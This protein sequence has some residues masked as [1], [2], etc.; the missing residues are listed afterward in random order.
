MAV[1]FQI[2]SSSWFKI[3]IFLCLYTCIKSEHYLNKFAVHIEGG[4]RVARDVAQLHGFRHL[5]QIGTLE[6]HYLFEHEHV[7]RRSAERSEEHHQKLSSHPQVNWFE[8]QTLLT[9]KKRDFLPIK[10]DTSEL[11]KSNHVHRN[12]REVNRQ[13]VTFNDE[14]YSKMWYFNGGGLNHTD[15]N[16]KGAWAK[17]VT[18]KDVVITILDD[19]LERTHDDLKDNY[20]PYASY[21]VNG[22][23]PDP[24]PR[25]DYTNENRHGTRCAGEVSAKANNTKCVVGVAYNSKIG[26]VRMLDGD[27]YDAVEATSLSHNR[28]H[29]DIYSASWGPDDDG[30]VVDGPGQLAKKAFMDGVRLG[31]NG[32]GAIFVWASGNGGRQHDS[33]SC[34]G[35]TNSIYTLSISG[36]S[37]RI[38]KPFYLEECAST[39]ATTFSS[40]GGAEKKIVTVDLHNKCT[41]T[42]TGTSASAP[43]AAGIIALILEVNP[44]L[45]WRD[46]QYITL[47]TARPLPDGQ[48]V[49]N[50][51]GRQVS[52]RY[53]YGLM[54]ATAMVELAEKWTVVPTQHICEV[55]SGRV[56]VEKNKITI[57]DSGYEEML[58]TD[59][60]AGNTN[61]INFLEHVQAK[62][63]LKS[64]RRGDIVIHLTSPSGTRST[65]LPQRPNDG[66][67]VKGFNN[68]QF[69]SVHFWGE[70]PVGRWKLEIEVQKNS[71]GYIGGSS[72]SGLQSTNDLIDWNLSL[73]GT[74]ENPVNL[75]NPTP[76]TGPTKPVSPTTK[77]PLPTEAVTEKQPCH[78]QCLN[79]CSGPGAQQCTAC[80]NYQIQ[81]SGMCVESC[82]NEYY[83][84]IYQC[85]HCSDP[86]ETCT[87]VS[88]KQVMCLKCKPGY[89]LIEGKGTCEK[90]CDKGYYKDDKMHHCRVCSGVCDE[91]LDNKNKCT[92]CRSGQVLEK[93]TCVPER[94][95]C[96]AGTF[97]SLGG[98]KTCPEGCF[99][100]TSYSNCTCCNKGSYLQNGSCVHS[101]DSGF[102]PLH[103]NYSSMFVFQQCQQCGN[104]C[105]VCPAGFKYIKGVCIQQNNCP[106]GTYFQ[107]NSMSC[108]KCNTSCRACI[109]PSNTDCL[110]CYP[111]SGYNN[112]LRKCMRCCSENEHNSKYKD[113]C[114]CI[115]DGK[116][117]I[118]SRPRLQAEQLYSVATVIIVLLVI[119]ICALAIFAVVAIVISCR[120]Q[121]DHPDVQYRQLRNN[122][123]EFEN[124]TEEA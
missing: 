57:P 93:D 50:G 87:Y 42:H 58:D 7:H 78:S 5:G 83:A 63:T 90:A 35:Y 106:D 80:K 116:C 47:M 119:V 49:T 70:N 71:R 12:R 79:G 96:P 107:W 115:E 51:V 92:A 88:T 120:K 33:C 43:L 67:R 30:R 73:Y 4:E 20:D 110:S 85:K 52:L 46:V 8:Q 38:T 34:D 53:G 103:V 84:D 19:G 62:I 13:D 10:V 11:L 66:D 121:K 112:L 16:V 89:L 18:G 64:K 118:K 23:K 75:V 72:Y 45:T 22:H 76:P 32:K 91:C 1:F 124:D 41:E 77:G 68:W 61:E 86:C 28:S 60:C 2:R 65:I 122:E 113:C 98:C 24:M 109:G 82:P 54:D 40:G 74:E 94:E 25:Y 14:L 101:C 100:C 9:R 105:N 81:D 117:E 36:V 55:Q 95:P 111:P 97:Q 56:S 39:L 123:N 15:M 27:V 108:K 99:S 3:Y 17:G 31:R 37:Q 69:L 59:A 104:E 102:Q 114:H 48:W 44:S 6:D 26:G 29:I 21:D